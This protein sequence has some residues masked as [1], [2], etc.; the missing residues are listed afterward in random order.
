[1]PRAVFYLACGA[2]VAA[3]VSIFAYQVLLGAAVAAI[4]I[5]RQR[6]RLPP[7]GVW[8][9]L[10][11]L[12]TLV[13]L[14]LSD[15]PK[16]GWP[17]VKKF[18]VYLMLPV[19]FTAVR[20]IEDIRRLVWCWAAAASASGLWSFVEF[21]RKR[22]TALAEGNDFYTAYVADRVTGFLGHWMTFGAVQMTALLLLLSLFLFAP[23]PRR[24]RWLAVAAAGIIGASIAIGWTR[25]V[26]LAAAVSI[27]YL[28]AVWRPKFLLLA[29]VALLLGWFVA[30]R[31]IRER[32]ISI[33]QPHGNIDSNQHRSITRRVGMEMIK[34]H[35]WFGIG[36]EMPG[37]QFL[38]YLPADI[39]TPLPEGF[40][41]HL[42]NVYLQYGA[43][44]GLPA[45]GVFLC[46]IGTIL[47]HWWRKARSAI[48]PDIQGLLHGCIAALIALL[49]EA[50]F[51]HNLGD[52]EVL[53]MFWVVVAWGYGAWET[54]A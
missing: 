34:S 38:R 53:G 52:S 24:Y 13:A 35:P 1:M 23:P 19:V 10:F 47:V 49:I 43:E 5:Y 32:V 29:P 41:G 39:P 8:L 46:M 42:H 17:Q 50:F 33:Y 7:I 27:V 6:L 21:W 16:A 37:K 44:R 4:L 9:G 45:L 28:V 30:P 3:P 11:V 48:S 54:E 22:Q 51:E 18:Y 40:Y 25:S 14:A 20:R 31:S 36:P 26:W 12:L 2:A 15:D